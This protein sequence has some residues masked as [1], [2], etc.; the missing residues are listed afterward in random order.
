MTAAPATTSP[1]P[2]SQPARVSPF[3]QP[4]A[5]WAVAF[6]CV[7]SFM[8]IGLV[9]PILPALRDKLHATPAQVELLFTSYLVVTAVAMLVTGWVSTRIGA[10]RT[11]VA[12][13]VLIV[14][15]SALAGSSGGISQIVGFRAGW[16][17]GNALFI[18]TS[19]AVIVASASG[20]FAGAII[21][22]ETALGVGI[23]LGPLLGGELGAI[24]WRGPFFGVTALMSIALIA[25]LVL[26]EKTPK[27][28]HRTSILDPL[29]ALRHR[30]LLT[31]GLTALCYNWAFFTVLGYAPFPMN[32]GTDQL[33]YVFTCWGVLVAIFAIFVAP[34]LERRLGVAKALYLNLTLFAVDVLVIALYTT[35]RT[36]LIAAVIVSGAFIGINNTVT[37]QAVMTVAPVERPVASAAYGFIRFI[38]AGLAPYVAGRLAAAYNVHLPF[39]IGAGVVVAGIII[40]ST[41]HRL[42]NVATHQVQPASAAVSQ[43]ASRPAG[44]GW[45]LLAVDGSPASAAVA[46]RAA[47]VAAARGVGVEIMHV[48]ETDVVDTEA[49]ELE[50]AEQSERVVHERLAQLQELGVPASRY[51]VTSTGDHADVGRLIARR[52]R[53]IQAGLIAVGAPTGRGPLMAGAGALATAQLASDAPCDVL[54]VQPGP[55]L[56]PALP[57]AGAAA[58]AG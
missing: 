22:Y 4:R 10:K 12:G 57:S 14:I 29:R 54:V 42:L 26:V 55:E 40:L 49:I 25:T 13:L 20:G 23:A 2:T 7:I 44:P 51:L 41:G 8:G 16:G 47:A 32:L 46:S 15:F 30:G 18:A 43:P 19:L 33:G 45:V 3:H 36:V 28:A 21:L 48:R 11:L 38:G 50:P 37:T 39:Y 27:P 9:D 24:S 53:D 58:R 35:N 5:V 17:L 31:M 34:R 1:T 6:A 52:A 56:T